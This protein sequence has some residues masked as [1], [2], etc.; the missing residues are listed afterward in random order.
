MLMQKMALQ[1]GGNGVAVGLL[2]LESQ[3][4][5]LTTDDYESPF[6]QIEKQSERP[7]N[8]EE[9]GRLKFCHL[10]YLNYFRPRGA[11]A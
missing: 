11:F 2:D 7:T 9:A 10:N 5:W 3:Y 8:S 1:L 6:F 4:R